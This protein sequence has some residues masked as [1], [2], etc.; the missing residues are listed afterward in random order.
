M[1]Q[2]TRTRGSLIA[3]SPQRKIVLRANIFGI[4][5]KHGWP[6]FFV[7]LNPNDLYSPIQHLRLQENDEDYNT[8]FQIL[9][10]NGRLQAPKVFNENPVQCAKYFN[11]VVEIVLKHVFGWDCDNE[12][13]KKSMFGIVKAHFGVVEQQQRKQLHLHM[14]VWV[15]GLTDYEIFKEKMTDYHF[16][17][18]ILEYLNRIIRC[19][20]DNPDDLMEHD[21]DARNYICP[22]LKNEEDFQEHYNAQL[23]WIQKYAQLHQCSRY[24]CLKRGRHCRY[25][26]P[27]AAVGLTEYN[28]NQN[29]IL[30]KRN[31]PF[32]NN[33]I[34]PIAVIGRFNTDIQF[35]PGNGDPRI[36]RYI[37][38]YCSNYTSKE[39]ASNI[40]LL[41]F[42]NQ[43]L[44]DIQEYQPDVLSSDRRLFGS[45]LMKTVQKFSSAN[46]VGAVEAASTLLGFSDHYTNFKFRTIDWKNWD[47]WICHQLGEAYA[48]HSYHFNR[49]TENSYCSVL[50]KS[51]YPTD[52]RPIT[53][54]HEAM[55]MKQKYLQRNNELEK[56]S[57][58]EMESLFQFKLYSTESMPF[59]FY[60]L[61]GEK[62]VETELVKGHEELQIPSV[63]SLPWF[64]PKSK[65]HGVGTEAFARIMCLLFRRFRNAIDLF[66]R[67][68]QTFMET[69][70]EWKRNLNPKSH[71]YIYIIWKKMASLQERPLLNLSESNVKT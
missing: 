32:L 55:D 31:N 39:E 42:M 41:H 6:S 43:K 37:A 69:Y 21:I 4:I 61:R 12:S 10:N 25:K 54:S 67:R 60:P 16:K 62:M 18:N 44:K 33:C 13:Y 46:D 66:D 29:T 22:T 57:I 27:K 2:Q 49:Y 47:L 63:P 28:Q 30:M 11:A 14:L 1:L 35:L 20:L 19:S 52:T 68:R 9:S 36:A 17:R 64:N 56:Y 71:I 48:M 40:H 8:L 24:H 45:L 65:T 26:F 5:T 34:P 3:H 15:E 7:T 58:Y 38:Y 53:T 51:L 70:E 59:N 23:D 50:Q